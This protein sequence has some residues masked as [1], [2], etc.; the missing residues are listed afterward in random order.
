MVIKEEDITGCGSWWDTPLLGCAGRHKAKG[1]VTSCFSEE[2]M[3]H[4][5]EWRVEISKTSYVGRGP[6]QTPGW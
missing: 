3:T 1:Q 4:I 2:A 5:L 6:L